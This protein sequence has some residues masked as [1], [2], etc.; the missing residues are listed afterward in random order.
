MSRYWAA[1]VILMLLLV[2]C[3][4]TSGGTYV[5]IG[6][7]VKPTTLT[8]ENLVTIEAHA[9]SPEGIA[10]VEIWVSG[11]LVDTILSPAGEESLA[12]YQSG[13]SP[14]GPGEYV[15]QALATG[16]NG[17]ASEPDTTTVTIS[18]AVSAA[19]EPQPVEEAAQEP[20]PTNT[21]TL[22][23]EEISPVINFWAEPAE[24][25]AGGCTTIYWEVSNVSK[26]EF[27]DRE[28]QFSGSYQDCMCET[29]TYPMI[30]TYLDG[31]RGTFRVTI[32]VSGVCATDTPTPP[33]PDTT[34]PSDPTTLKPINGRE[35]K[36]G[37]KQ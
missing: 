10:M 23:P 35:S 5:W 13:F 30:I 33:P 8:N 16:S 25:Q 2:G 22:V 19:A 20:T 18:E 14:T 26:V 32:N 15:I 27:G 9:T 12:E 4:G 11:S 24:I 28:Q 6:V 37:G 17:I 21:P 1:P 34:G 36:F 3:S 29:Q 7:P 31:S